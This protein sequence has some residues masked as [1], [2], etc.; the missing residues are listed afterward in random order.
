MTVT[1][2]SAQAPTEHVLDDEGHFH[3]TDA[4]IDLSHYLAEDWLSLAFFWLLG[5]NVFFQFFT[6]Y[7]LNDS[8]AWT[9]EIARY[10]L[11]GTV[12]VGVAI[13]VAKNMAI[14]VDFFYRFLP[15]AAGRWMSRLVDVLRIAFFGGGGA[16]RADDGQARQ[17]DADDD[18]RCAD[19]H[20]LRRRPPRL[21]RA[22]VPLGPGGG[23]PLEA[24]LERPRAPHD[25]LRRH[26]GGRPPC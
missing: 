11:I 23:A 5:A 25:D 22:D 26:L 12:F 21:R 20:R 15:A 6:R 14:Q 3:A 13:G 17:L 16:H 19:E 4:P 7:A 24:R 9:E 1:N 8:A 2:D 18:R 10:L